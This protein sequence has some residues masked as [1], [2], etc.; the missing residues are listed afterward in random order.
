MPSKEDLLK[1][2]K[3]SS[4]EYEENNELILSLNK[5][6]CNNLSQKTVSKSKSCLKPSGSQFTLNP[7]SNKAGVHDLKR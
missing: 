1:Y 5:S 7:V 6:L 2:I 3:D 4:D